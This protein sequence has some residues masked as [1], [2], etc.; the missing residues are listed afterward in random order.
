MGVLGLR[1]GLRLRLELKQIKIIKRFY[2][3][4]LTTD[5]YGNEN[6]LRYRMESP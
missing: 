6:V 4:I 3:I 2:I 1:G 5:S